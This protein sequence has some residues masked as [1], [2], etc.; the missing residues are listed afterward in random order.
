MTTPPP[1]RHP[2]LRAMTR[3]VGG[4][5]ERARLPPSAHG[6]SS[7]WVSVPA[8]GGTRA[9]R[10]GACPVRSRGT[11]SGERMG[12]PIRAPGSEPVRT[13]SPPF[14]VAHA[15]HT[16]VCPSPLLWGPHVQRVQV[17]PGLSALL[18]LK[19]WGTQNA[20]RKPG[21]LE[22]LHPVPAAAPPH[23]SDI[24]EPGPISCSAGP[25]KKLRHR[26]KGT[27]C[28]GI[29]GERGEPGCVGVNGGA[30]GGT[31][32]SRGA[33]GCGAAPCPRRPR[34][35][36]LA[37]CRPPPAAA[38]ARPARG[39]PLPARLARVGSV[40]GASICQNR[41]CDA[42]LVAFRFPPLDIT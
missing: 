24:P 30:P 37:G 21:L 22:R 16:C 14:G 5:R 41:D 15:P 1:L 39:R 26:A 12:S 11:P 27:V 6:L 34:E 3:G 18:T 40:P 4:L 29:P 25:R 8:G 32:V 2:H 33:L 42:H 10:E 38:R 23:L 7:A 13:H 20:P 35:P 19:N 28:P 17:S 36:L 9:S 31:E